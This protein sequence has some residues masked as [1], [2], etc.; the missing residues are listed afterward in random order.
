MPPRSY[1]IT[2]VVL[3]GLVAVSIPLTLGFSIILWYGLFAAAACVLGVAGAFRVAAG[4]RAP[5]WIGVALA[6]PG[7]VWGANSLYE[8]M[9]T[10]PS[11]ATASAFRMAADLTLLA[12]GAAAL[13]LVETMSRP[14][15]AFRV[16]YGLLAAPALLLGV[17]V[18]ARVSGSGFTNDALYAT[19]ARAVSVAATSVSYGAFIGAAVLITMRRDIE[20]WTGAVI[21][22]VGAAT[23]C[24]ALSLLF[25]GELLGG[26]DGLLFWL[27]PVIMLVGGAALWRMGSLLRAQALAERAAAGIAS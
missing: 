5:P 10:V 7:I 24:K 18:L 11:L 6:S 16:G 8:L 17:T 19:L 26:G 4:L 12:A 21:S 15:A 3:A 14:R 25:P 27:Q 2:A 13:R 22:L 1:L 20:R 9:V 23:L